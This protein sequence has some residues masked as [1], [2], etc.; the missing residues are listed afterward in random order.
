M[1]RSWLMKSSV[2]RWLALDVGEELGDRGLDRD[3]ERRDRLV[4]DDDGGA[5][6]E[7]AGDADALLLAAG[8][9]AR[10]ARGEGAGQAD[11]VEELEHPGLALGVGAAD[12]EFLQRANDLA[13]DA[14]ARVEGVEGVLE[15]HLQR[16]DGAGLARLDGGAADLGGAEGDR[17]RGGGLE[18]EEHLGQRRLSA[19]ALADD[20]EGFGLAG[21]EADRTRWPSPPGCRRRRGRWSRPGSTCAGRR[22]RARPRRS[23]RARRSR[24][25]RGAQPSRSRPSGCSGSRGW[26]SPA[27]SGC[28][29]RRSARRRNSC[30][31]ARSCS[32]AGARGAGGTGPG[33]APADGGCGRRRGGGGRG[34]A[35]ACRD[36]AFR[37]RPRRSGRSRPPRPST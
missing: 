3:V 4:G 31:A 28:R 23:V 8:E 24:G 10:P 19:A 16:G 13:A 6:G 12:A 18:A 35:P 36:G 17:T 7:G 26:A 15:D 20:G 29:R 5:A 37:R 9:L 22:R 25:R 34:T 27:P 2:V 21:V 30:S 11:E 32:R 1:P 33:S 14:H